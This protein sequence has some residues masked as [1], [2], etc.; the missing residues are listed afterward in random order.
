MMFNSDDE[1]EELFD[2][3]GTTDANDRADTA[4]E[5]A[6]WER[7]GRWITLFFFVSLAC[8]ILFS[9]VMTG[10]TPTESA[11]APE[12]LV[13]GLRRAGQGIAPSGGNLPADLFHSPELATQFVGDMEG[14]RQYAV[15]LDGIKPELGIITADR[16]IDPRAFEEALFQE[17]GEA[18]TAL[19][20][21]R[22]G[23][24][25][26]LEQLRQAVPVQKKLEEAATASAEVSQQLDAALTGYRE[27]TEGLRAIAAGESSA[28]AGAGPESGEDALV[29]ARRADFARTSQR[30]IDAFAG[31]GQRG[32]ADRS[33][34]HRSRSGKQPVSGDHPA[35]A[36]ALRPSDEG[37][38]HREE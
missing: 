31:V 6:Q 26:E 5:N 35:R 25:D 8:S 27:T 10:S 28:L 7:Y 29:Q 9:A 30:I 3:F 17:V 23:Q 21:T 20:L 12:S 13:A 11:P 37:R 34:L 1:D 14:L 4:D 15:E 18:T 33:G 22:Q 38:R 16:N 2:E 32:V 24:R 19:G 36:T